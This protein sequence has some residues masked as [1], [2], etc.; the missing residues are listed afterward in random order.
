MN[1]VIG[2]G[3]SGDLTTAIDGHVMLA[4]PFAQGAFNAVL[5]QRQPEGVSRRLIRHVQEQ[6]GKM[7]YRCRESLGCEAVEDAPLIKYFQG[8]RGHAGGAR[9][10]QFVRGAPLD[11]RDIGARQRQLAGQHQSR[12]PAS[13]NNHR[14]LGHGDD[15][16]RKISKLR[17]L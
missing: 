11:D 9:A 1:G 5:Q 3:E 12:W 10:V 4:D 7:R 15:A 13:G 6:R 8:A 14:M 17:D 2:R 16:T